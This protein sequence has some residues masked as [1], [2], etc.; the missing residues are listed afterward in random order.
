[1]G[2]A[3]VLSEF[4]VKNKDQSGSARLLTKDFIEAAQEG[5]EE[6]V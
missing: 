5:I 1:M 4:K 2:H 6:G 3:K